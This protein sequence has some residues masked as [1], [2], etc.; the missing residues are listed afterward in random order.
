[1]D[2]LAAY[3]DE[4]RD[5]PRERE[6]F[7]IHQD[8]YRFIL[9]CIQEIGLPRGSRVLDAGCYP[10]HLLNAVA[11]LGYEVDG[12]CSLHEPVELPNVVGLNI[13]SDPLP[14]PDRHFDLVLFTELIEHLTVDPR[15]YLAEVRRVLKPDGTLL[16]T[17]PNAVHLKNRV[18]MMIGRSPA[19]SLD[20][21]FETR[22]DDGS[23]Y[24]RHNREYTAAELKTVVEAAGFTVKR[25][26][27]FNSYGP[28]RERSV[29]DPLPARI[30]KVGGWLLTHLHPSL[31]D[32][33]YL[34]MAKR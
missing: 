3:R 2:V 8:R 27:R 32:S 11:A 24:Y 15:L 10:P 28:F 34:L 19:F 23:I 20:Q 7:L 21:L 33:L 4:L 16:I 9:R 17:T 25:Q 31:R 29:P 14:F 30:A 1:M 22:P 26:R 5:R 13:E 18:L 12:I 6:Y